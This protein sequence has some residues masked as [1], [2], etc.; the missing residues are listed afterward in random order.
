M[1]LEDI[2]LSDLRVNSANDRH[3]ELIDEDAAIEWL[4]KHR[5]L[6]M[7]N[8]AKDIV[9]T[10]AIYEPPLVHPHDGH[11]IVYDGNRRTS[12][13]KLLSV[14]QRAPSSDWADFFS[15]LRENWTGAFPSTVECQIEEDRD[16][17]D[18]ILYRR[19]TGQ[20]S[21][22]GQS[23]WDAEAKSN[24]ERRT[25]KKT[26]INV[27]EEIERLLISSGRI[28]NELKIPRSNL[29]R[30]LSAEQFRNR[31]GI[32][33]DSNKLRYTH[34]E[35]KVLNALERIARDLSSRTITLED[36]WDNDSKRAYLNKLD[37]EKV[38]PRSEDA[39]PKTAP[40]KAKSTQTKTSQKESKPSS[41][42]GKRRHLIRNLDFGFQ[43]TQKNR[44]IL[45][46]F[47]E[48]QHRLKFDEHDNAIAVLFRVLLELSLEHYIE[49]ASV[50]DIQKGDKLSNKYRK[51]L[52]HMFD[53]GK[54]DKKQIDAL[55]KFETGDPLFSTTTLHS[56]VHSADFFP[57]DHHLKS[58]WDT[59]ES[60][61]VKCLKA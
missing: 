60:F 34:D 19:H 45:D 56:Y 53:T 6:H 46:I 23:Q 29:N 55:K 59:L 42:P 37:Q 7:Q 30:L 13:L 58:M 11:F 8:L 40:A 57:S 32:A 26:K 51:T 31:A 28:D 47:N 17:L 20:Q 21:G 22:V 18:E 43:Q 10:G 25:G 1:K 50:T 44:K 27:A 2:K 61:I 3:G 15:N 14:P 33:V 41:D 16:R 35:D 36:I 9:S 49:A 5:T 38:L 52:T 4:L 39:L 54:I 48:L 24:F 12:V